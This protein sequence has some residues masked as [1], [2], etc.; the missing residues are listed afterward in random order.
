M[1]NKYVV[2]TSIWIKHGL[3][4]FIIFTLI[5]EFQVDEYHEANEKF[6]LLIRASHPVVCL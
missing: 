2:S 6:F 4:H 3:I 5:L 1:E